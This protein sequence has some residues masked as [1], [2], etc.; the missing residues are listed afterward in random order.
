MDWPRDWPDLVAILVNNVKNNDS[1]ILRYRSLLI[2]NHVVKTLS[3]KRL[4]GDKKLFYELSANIYPIM[5]EFWDFTVANF[6]A[7][8]RLFECICSFYNKYYLYYFHISDFAL[9]RIRIATRPHS[10]SVNWTCLS[11]RPRYYLN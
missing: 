1:E 8:V 2:L 11:L 3:A 7:A 9:C 4:A 6:L 5:Y 10:I